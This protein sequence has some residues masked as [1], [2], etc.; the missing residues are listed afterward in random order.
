MVVSGGSPSVAR[1]INDRS[2]IGP[3]AVQLFLV[4][5]TIGTYTSTTPMTNGAG[6]ML[7]RG[8][9]DLHTHC[10]ADVR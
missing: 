2:Q 5:K 3:A 6:G 1:E 8:S 10:G 7:V 9:T 4:S